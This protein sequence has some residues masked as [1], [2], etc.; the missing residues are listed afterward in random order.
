MAA[1]IIPLPFR[2][3]D[4]PPPP[5]PGGHVTADVIPLQGT[6]PSLPPPDGHV[7]LSDVPSLT[8]ATYRQVDY[9][10]RTG[11]LKAEPK[12]PGSGYARFVA[13]DEVA[14]VRVAATLI[15][16]LGVAHPAKA[17]EQA[18]ELVATGGLVRERHGIRVRVEVEFEGNGVSDKDG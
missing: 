13:D 15:N 14:V 8:G 9:W 6:D 10:T 17:F 1:D 2:E 7:R 5:P 12:A 3:T 4:P 11:R 16:V 18:R